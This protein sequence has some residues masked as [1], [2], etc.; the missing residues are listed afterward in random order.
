MKI[1]NVGCGGNRPVKEPWINIDNLHAI[2]PDL[3]RPERKN[4]DAEFNYLNADLRNGIP[5]ENDSVEGILASHF[6]EH[7]DT[8]ESLKFLR[9]CLRVLKSGG[10]LRLSVPDPAKFYKL[11]IEGC[12]NWGEPNPYTDRTFMEFALF[13]GEHKQ[14]VG[15]DALNCMLNVVGFK[16]WYETTSSTTH[17]LPLADID[18]RA[19]FS[20]F[21]EASK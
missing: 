13:F 10:I 8:Q 19:I 1:L 17:L 12:T 21:V 7:L 20:L 18:N 16:T 14:L 15:I 11:T 3:T 9:E 5:F 6:L 4:M 2:F